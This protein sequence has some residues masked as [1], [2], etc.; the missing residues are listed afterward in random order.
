HYR[1]TREFNYAGRS[2]IYLA[3]AMAISG[4][5]LGANMGFQTSPRARYFHTFLNLRLGWWFPN[6]AFPGSWTGSV[7]RARVNMLFDELLGRTDEK[8]PYVYLSDG[9]HFENLGLYE[10]VRRKCKLIIISDAAQDR[11]HVYQALGNA[12]QHCRADFGVEIE[13]NPEQVV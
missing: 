8:G 11:Q 5:A 13:L 6:P 1:R 10:L 2:R 9:G 7:P 4:S 12:I 3:Q